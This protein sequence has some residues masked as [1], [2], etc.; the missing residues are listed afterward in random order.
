MFKHILIPTDGSETS[1]RAIH[2]GITFACDSG[3]SVTGLYVMPEYS[4]YAYQAEM[5]VDTREEFDREC[6]MSHSRIPAL[7]YR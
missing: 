3:A 1:K 5:L 4:V 6:V 2:A 7:V